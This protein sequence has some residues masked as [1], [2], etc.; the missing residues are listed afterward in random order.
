MN[1]APKHDLPPCV[2]RRRPVPTRH[3]SF[4]RARGSFW[5]H[6]VRPLSPRHS[7]MLCQG[8]CLLAGDR[9]IHGMKPPPCAHAVAMAGAYRCWVARR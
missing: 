3:C 7:Y 1:G 2:S 4:F 8:V 5:A 9:S 6:S